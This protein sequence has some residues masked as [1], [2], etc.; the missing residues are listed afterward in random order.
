M[1][2]IFPAKNESPEYRQAR[3]DLDFQLYCLGE[4]ETDYDNY[5]AKVVAL[6]EDFQ[7]S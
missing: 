6:R 5:C 3:V 2:H 7:L 1:D 4:T